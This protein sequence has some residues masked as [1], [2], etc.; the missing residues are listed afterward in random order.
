MIEL[1]YH[2][3]AILNELMDPSLTTTSQ[4]NLQYPGAPEGRTQHP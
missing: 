3:F 2:Y 1:Q 4:S